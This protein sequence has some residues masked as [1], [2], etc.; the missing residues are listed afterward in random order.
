M[1]IIRRNKLEKMIY[2]KRQIINNNK[3]LSKRFISVQIHKPALNEL[4]NKYSAEITQPKIRGNAQAM[5]HALDLDAPLS[6]PHIG[7]G[8]VWY[9][10]NPC[11]SKLNELSRRIKDSVME[12]DMLGFQFNTVGI[13][14]GITMGTESM[15]YSLPSRDLICDS[16]ELQTNGGFYDG[17]V[18]IPG[19]D[20]NLPGIFMAL[21]KLN[22]P[23]LMVYGG[24]MPPS[25]SPLDG[26]DLDIVSS[27]EAYGEY[28]ANKITDEER[29]IIIQNSCNK[30]CGACSGLYTANTMASIIEIMG[31]SLPNS[32]TN[33]SNSIHKFQECSVIGEVMRNLIEKD[34]KPSD[35][36]TK[37]SFENAIKLFII[38][39]GSTN[40]VPHLLAIA[41]AANIDLTLDDF[42]KHQN[43]PVLAN[44]KPHGQYVMNDLHTHQGMNYLVNYL[45]DKN[46]INGNCMTVTGKPLSD[47]YEY[48]PSKL[49]FV[50]G[51][52]HNIIQPVEK[53]FKPTSH[54]R[55]LKGNLAPEGCVS[56]IYYEDNV[57]E[58]EVIVFDSEKEMI[59]AL[60][61]HK[62]KKDHFVV[63][64][65]QGETTGCPEMLSPTSALIGYFGDEAPP[66]ATDGRFSGGSKGIL[67]AHLPDAYKDTITTIL[68]DGDKIKIDL[69][70]NSINVKLWTGTNYV[71]EISDEVVNNI[72]NKFDIKLKT[73]E[74]SGVLE[75]YAKLVSGLSFGYST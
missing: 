57:Y 36:L 67:V 65:Y 15:R 54:I 30:Q 2:I 43:I 66:L 10:S 14:D 12:N 5:L 46:I 20:K 74:S 73:F 19:C 41:R 22:R 32:A 56:K 4:S 31:M 26:K 8:A 25:T 50:M 69:K 71:D 49:N 53:P 45:I 62:I 13:S 29:E 55:I 75:K 3:F 37:D 18:G 44:M 47:N 59:E 39:G 24:A 16:F 52:F 68:K 40:A 21:C 48:L 61:Q 42:I 72:K 64:R 38:L 60:E 1:P 7:I 28:V 51:D 35:I 33:P 27:F 6:E 9:E 23:S 34:I 11:N 17:V 70:S 58:G 63:I